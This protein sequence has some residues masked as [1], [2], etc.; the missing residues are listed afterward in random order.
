METTFQVSPVMPA[1][2]LAFLVSDF[3]GIESNSPTMPAQSFYS[4]PNAKQ[5]LKFALDYSIASLSALEDYFS[6]KFPLEKIDNAAIP[7]F[8]PGT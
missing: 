6:L 7:D 1:Y 5:H 8:L 2:S 4:W 3:E